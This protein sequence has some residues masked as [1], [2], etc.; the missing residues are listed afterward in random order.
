M[1]I[2]ESQS[3]LYE[4]MIGRNAAF[5]EPI[6]GKLVETFEDELRDVTFKEWV[7]AINKP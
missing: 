5:W 7:R 1:G 6:Y 4:N 3:R 2:H